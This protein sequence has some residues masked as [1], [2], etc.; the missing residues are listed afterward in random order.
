MTARPA[1]VICQLK[2]GCKVSIPA[3]LVRFSTRGLTTT[4][5]AVCAKTG[6]TPTNTKKEA[7]IV[8]F[9]ILHYKILN[10]FYFKGPISLTNYHMENVNSYPLLYDNK[11]SKRKNTNTI[12]VIISGESYSRPIAIGP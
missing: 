3:G 6:T 4:G 10:G 5:F 8:R 12:L 7:K 2:R 9:F 11:T 1:L